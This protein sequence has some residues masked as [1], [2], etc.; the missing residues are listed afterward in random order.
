MLEEAGGVTTMDALAAFEELG[1]TSLPTSSTQTVLQK[2][3]DLSKRVLPGSIEVSVTLLSQDKATT[4]VYTGTL[5]RDLDESQYGRGYGPCLEA[6]AGGQLIELA[7]ARTEQRWPDYARACVERGSLS[8]LSVPLPIQQHVSGALNIYAHEAR[9]F[10]SDEVQQLATRFA[11]YAGVGVANMQAFEDARGMAAHLQ[12]AMDS[13]ATIEQAKGILMERFKVTSDQA[14][15]MLAQ[16]S[17]T[18]N[19]KLRD[20]ADTLVETGELISS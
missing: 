16:A 7:D 15:R 9:A 17:M 11:A 12:A 13:R 2:V 19:R 14:F 4:A 10:G 8:S 1:R 3:A 6:A 18:R 20:V 5:A